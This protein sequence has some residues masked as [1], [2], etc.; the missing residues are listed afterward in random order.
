MKHFRWISF[1]MLLCVFIVSCSPSQEAGKTVSKEPVSFDSHVGEDSCEFSSLDE[2]QASVDT[3]DDFPSFDPADTPE[4]DYILDEKFRTSEYLPQY[5]M[6]N[7]YTRFRTICESE[8]AYYFWM[9]HSQHL[10]Y[11]D[12][13]SGIYG[14]LCGKPDCTHE[15]NNMSCNA[16]GTFLT[17][18]S[19]Y[20]HHLYWAQEDASDQRFRLMRMDPDGTNRETVQVLASK[21][22]GMNP[23]V[24]LHRGYIYTAAIQNKVENAQ[25]ILSLQITQEKLVSE[26]QTSVTVF[27]KDYTGVGVDYYFQITGNTMYIAVTTTGPDSEMHLYLYEYDIA[28]RMLRQFTD[29]RY[30]NWLVSDFYADLSGIYVAL[31]QDSSTTYQIEKYNS[32]L[33]RF[34]TS[35]E[36][37][38]SRSDL[39]PSLG[40]EVAVGYT[41][42]NSP[43]YYI[44]DYTGHFL[45]EGTL[46][47]E[48]GQKCMGIIL[49]G[50]N[51]SRIL[52]SYIVSVE[53]SYLLNLFEIPVAS[54]QSVT[55]LYQGTVSR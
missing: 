2:S 36:V 21:A 4:S 14:K 35:G 27:E 18:L 15:I 20:D 8:E 34:E 55:T 25:N 29:E 52:I 41:G 53:N 5:D 7:E 48:E 22:T 26:S 40:A 54:P 32:A 43:Q 13:Q 23:M 38:S 3:L 24:R 17:G 42:G 44:T 6:Q 37:T 9:P 45:G 47:L 10:L 16:S 11:Y 49:F 39:Y 30:E 50:A 51:R 19:Y 31:Y 33:S 28:K 1:M 12:K 46:P